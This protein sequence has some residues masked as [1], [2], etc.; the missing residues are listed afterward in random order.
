MNHICLD[1][2]ELLSRLSAMTAAGL[3]EG[4]LAA[5][6][7]AGSSELGY[8]AVQAPDGNFYFAS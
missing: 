6:V 7:L 2:R 1:R 4:A 5:P 3:I 8:L